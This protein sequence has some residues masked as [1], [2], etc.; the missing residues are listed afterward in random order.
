MLIVIVLL[1]VL[2][3]AGVISH[4]FKKNTDAEEVSKAPEKIEPPIVADVRSA[5]S[6]VREDVVNKVQSTVSTTPAPA[7][8]VTISSAPA[9]KP[10][11]EPVKKQQSDRHKLSATP[12]PA[13]KKG[14]SN[15]K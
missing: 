8:K 3:T 9:P 15:K 5:V 1:V 7:K 2:I 4:S 6:V 10:K 11:V 13:Q 14:T 12:A